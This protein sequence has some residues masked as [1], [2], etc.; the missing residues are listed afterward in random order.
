M[1]KINNNMS[2][3][4]KHLKDNISFE[5]GQT[6]SSV[7]LPHL[8]IKYVTKYHVENVYEREKHMAS[9]LSKFDWYP[10]LLY[11]DD[12]NK[13]LVF[14]NVGKVL[15]KYNKPSDLE[16]KFNKILKDME[17]V[18]V[19][20]NDIKIGELLIDKDKKIYLCDFG[21]GS[22]NQNMNCGI[23]LWSCKNTNK[24]GGYYRDSETLERLK[25]N[26]IYNIQKSN[27][28]DPIRKVGSQKENPVI[29]YQGKHIHVSG[30][31][32]FIINEE[33]QEIKF[34]NKINKFSYISTLLHNLNK[35]DKCNSIV[36]FG[37]NS[38]LVSFIAYKQHFK[39]IL[40][41][42]HDS[43]Y[44]DTLRTIKNQCKITEI[45]EEQFSF[46]DKL[47][48][49][50][51]VVFCG[52][53][54]HWIF[55]LTADFRNFDKILHY[56]HSVTNKY[57]VIEWINENDYAI[58]SFNHIKKNQN[59]TDEEYTTE[60]FEKSINK[61]TNII[62]KQPVDGGGTRIIYVLQRT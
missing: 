21:W 29:K 58:E 36:D 37:C 59:P 57:L 52:A 34:L 20:H 24:P 2:G 8:F 55:S 42:D 49:S 13:I 25:F 45:N 19:Q 18:N 40:S 56:L 15:N 54:I 62:S 7:I 47:N 12:T 9:L 5:G 23:G 4:I 17:S 32:R 28:K 41:L 61:Y 31:Q 35:K 16:D 22:V 30:Y 53:I 10:P 51:D 38:G 3:I 11:S 33:T 1:F 26:N 60:N 44:I 6:S 43:E 14:K 46:G 50:F 39:R 48:E 27:Y